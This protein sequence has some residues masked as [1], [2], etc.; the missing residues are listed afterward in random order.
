MRQGS[1]RLR[2]F[3]VDPLFL[4]RRLVKCLKYQMYFILKISY[5][6]PFKRT[7]LQARDIIGF[8]LSFNNISHNSVS[9]HKY[10]LP[11]LLV[12]SIINIR[13]SR[14]HSLILRFSGSE[15]IIVIIF[16]PINAIQRVF[17]LLEQFIQPCQCLEVLGIIERFEEHRESFRFICF[18]DLRQGSGNVR[19]N[20]CHNIT[21]RIN[22]QSHCILCT[23]HMQLRQAASS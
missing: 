22:L 14:V 5:Q 15:I 8:I 23:C 4:S 11:F 20:M 6:I 12:I 10:K 16:M 17:T 18:Q 19:K 2:R 7:K 1:M 21:M 13:H 3:D 9:L